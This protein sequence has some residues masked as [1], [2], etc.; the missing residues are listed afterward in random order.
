MS[1]R[2]LRILLAVAG[3]VFMG[4]LAFGQA[5]NSAQ[6]HGIIT[7]PT[8]AAIV[9]AE[10]KATQIATG[11]V[12]TTT[13]GTE[14]NYNFPDLSVGPYQLEVKSQGFQNYVQKGITLQVS[15]NPRIDITLKVGTVTQTE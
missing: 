6:I 3:P 11:Q 13:S 9:G 15:E 12:R 10:I 7:D 4:A 14:G 2:L 8:G 5:I 1:G